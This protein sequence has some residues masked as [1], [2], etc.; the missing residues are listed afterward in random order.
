MPRVGIVEIPEKGL[1]VAAI[2]VD[3]VLVVLSR[4]DGDT[5]N[6]IETRTFLRTLQ[7]CTG[8]IVGNTGNGIETSPAFAACSARQCCRNDGVTGKRD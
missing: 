4:N 1:R 8:Q 2:A 7:A 5:G 3:Q 6:G